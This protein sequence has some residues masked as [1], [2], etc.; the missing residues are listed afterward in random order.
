MA[1]RD[2]YELLGLDRTSSDG[3]I[4]KAYRR[5]AM[6]CH[7]DRNPGDNDAE[8]RFKELS[9]AYGVLKDGEKRAAYDQFG[10]AAF[11]GASGG[12]GG[13][14]GFT[15]SSF[16]DVF[17]DLFG[18]FVGRRGGSS[19]HSGADLR[20]NL[21]ISLEDSYRGKSTTIRTTSAAT[22]DDCSGSGAAKGSSPVTCNAC[23]G[24][25][26]VRA[27][28]G[29]FTIERTCP[30][31]QGIGRIIKNMCG[32]CGG[33]GRI[34]KEK[35]LQ[36]NIPRGVDDEMRIRLSGEGEA[37][38]R[39][40]PPG[41]LYIFI[42]I[43]PHSLF[44]REGAELYCRVPLAMTQ[45][46]LGGMIEVPTLDGGRA[47]VTIPA[48]TQSGQQFR[49]RGKGMPAVRG[50]G[51]GDMIVQTK[52]ETPVNLTDKQEELLREFEK[53]GGKNNSPETDGFFTKV[54]ELWDD[55]RD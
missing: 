15:S 44:Q 54:K 6:E 19:A 53:N 5:L 20:Y 55:L 16:A 12:P 24:V 39:G 34:A 21:E 49:L 35:Q 33:G 38:V 36:V 10:H 50:K 9:E 31:C 1:K 26:K 42:K 11:D 45:A 2:Y 22:C 17:D 18:D 47:R 7:P 40:A 41:D 29:F 28:Q 14:F 30:T 37:G 25:G 48:G 3:D 4:K 52:V 32:A 46:V 13:G 8:K 43:S 51:F 23:Q 27:Q